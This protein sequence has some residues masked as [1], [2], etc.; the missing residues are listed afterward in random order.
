MSTDLP[1]GKPTS[2]PL[3]YSPDLLVGIPRAQGRDSLDLA[4]RLPFDGI[5]VWN[6]YELSWLNPRGKPVVAVAQLRIPASS[7]S[8][9]ESK[10]LK[11]Y[12]NSFNGARHESAAAVRDLIEEDLAHTVGVQVQV[13]LAPVSLGANVE[14]PSIGAPEGECIDDEDTAIDTYRVDPGLLEGCTT[15]GTEVTETL[16][17][18]LLKSN[19]PITG[20]PDWATLLI[21]YR[22]APIDRAALLR[23]IVSYRSHDDFHEHCVERIFVD[24]KRHCRPAALTVFAR[25]TRRGGVDINPFRS[26]FETLR[27]CE[28]LWRQ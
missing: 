21:R 26:D 27:D 23:Y 3:V 8:I 7:P 15:S 5:D 28:R 24:L 18:H 12:L 16:H 13:E 22:G 6:A 10:S 9:V 2:Y 11:L 17:S 19:C 20:Q 25:Y 14:A 4:S 1:L